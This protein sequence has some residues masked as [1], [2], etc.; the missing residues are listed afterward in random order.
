MK[1][2]FREPKIAYNVLI[3]Y[4]VDEPAGEAIWVEAK[5]SRKIR[6]KRPS[7]QARQGAPGPEEYVGSSTKNSQK[8]QRR[9]VTVNF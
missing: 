3:F 7:H 1:T 2:N 6:V 5:P 4:E 9:I 8:T